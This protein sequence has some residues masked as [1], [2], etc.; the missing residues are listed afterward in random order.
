MRSRGQSW[1]A[2]RDRISAEIAA[3]HLAPESRLPAEPDLCLLYNTRR[4]SLRRALAAL[5]AEGKLRVEHGRGTFVERAP[6]I[7]YVVGPR[8][9]FRENLMAQGLTGSGQALSEAQ[10]PASARV[11]AA[12]G[13]APGALVTARSWR[14][15][16]NDLPISLGW[17]YHDVARFPDIAERRKTNPSITQIYKTYGIADYRRHSTTVFTRLANEHETSLLM[18]RPGQSVL[19]VQKIDVDLDGRPI[20]FSEAAWA[21]DRVQFTFENADVRGTPS[22]RIDDV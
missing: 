20:G 9:R 7:N 22:E 12:L 5:V 19:I 2:T 3:G 11:A 16:A 10:V 17:S 18:M 14:G 15:F 21:G 13:I 4:H 6:L 1:E 8:T